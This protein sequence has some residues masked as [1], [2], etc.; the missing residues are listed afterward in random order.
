M[1]DHLTSC[2]PS[3]ALSILLRSLSPKVGA[4]L[5]APWERV[6]MLSFAGR[7]G[8]APTRKLFCEVQGRMSNAVVVDAATGA[9]LAAA[10]QVGAKQTRGAPVRREVGLAGYGWCAVVRKSWPS[11]PDPFCQSIS[12]FLSWVDVP[13]LRIPSSPSSPTLSPSRARAARQCG[14]WPSAGPTSSLPQPPAPTP[15]STRRCLP[16]AAE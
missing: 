5:A 16:G 4:E 15:R 9:V 7:P 10:L 3:S 2:L 6:A 14:P 13:L 1:N 12:R 8:E 11:S